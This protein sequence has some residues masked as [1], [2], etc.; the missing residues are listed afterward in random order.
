MFVVVSMSNGS[1]QDATDKGITLKQSC[2]YQ[3]RV[4]T[5]HIVLQ[6]YVTTF[7]ERELTVLTQCD[8]ANTANNPQCTLNNVIIVLM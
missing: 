8:H 2:S 6:K 1:T 3:F 5:N 4:I 7:C